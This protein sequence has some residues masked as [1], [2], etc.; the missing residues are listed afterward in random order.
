MNREDEGQTCV[1]LLQLRLFLHN[2][3]VFDEQPSHKSEMSPCFCNI[4]KCL[5]APCDIAVSVLFLERSDKCH[6]RI[7]T[8]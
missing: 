4:S 7:I 6:S 8:A 1:N 5:T 2:L 3:N